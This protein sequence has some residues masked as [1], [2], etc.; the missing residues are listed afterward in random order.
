MKNFLVQ[1][2]LF[3]GLLS[4]LMMGVF[5]AAG[6]HADGLYLKFATPRQSS[7]ILGTSKAAQGLHPSVFNEVFKRNDMF[8]YS[9]TVIHSPYGPVYLESIKNKLDKSTTGG[10]F[11]LTVDPHSIASRSE[12]PNDISNFRENQS[13]VGQIENVT[14]N[15]N[16]DYLINHYPEQYIYLL[17]R[18]IKYVSQGEVHPDGWVATN[19]TSEKEAVALRTKLKIIDYKELVKTFE[20]SDVRLAYLEKTIN[21]LKQYGSVYMVRLPVVGPI[22]ELENSIIP[23][24]EKKIQALSSR[25]NIPYLNLAEN[26]EAYSYDDGNHLDEASGKAASRDIALWIQSTGQLK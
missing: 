10:I 6:G 1:S 11:I 25:L 3:L 16:L 15:P 18:R 22:L 19:M 5:Y 21:Y 12:D 2:L 23:D 13:A 24:F 26:L 8:N 14:A 4:I 17:T 7:M 20:F 9:F